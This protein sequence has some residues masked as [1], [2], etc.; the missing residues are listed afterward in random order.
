MYSRQVETQLHEI[1][2]LSVSDYI[3]QSPH[4]A[5]LH[6]KIRVGAIISSSPPR[7]RSVRVA[8][9]RVL[10]LACAWLA[11]RLGVVMPTSFAQLVVFLLSLSV[12]LFIRSALV[13]NCA[14][15]VSAPSLTHCS[16]H[17][18]TY[19]PTCMPSRAWVSAELRRSS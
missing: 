7:A 12:H 15:H 1:E 16:A 19:L 18:P 4:M 11:V 8:H 6:G 9:S 13:H 3:A 5:A 14:I 2:R 10:C 17:L